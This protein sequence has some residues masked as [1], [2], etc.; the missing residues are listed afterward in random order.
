LN[1]I[2][3]EPSNSH[4]A[5]NNPLTKDNAMTRYTFKNFKEVSR[6]I[7][8]RQYDKIMPYLLDN[9]D[10][11]FNESHSSYYANVRKFQGFLETMVPAYRVFTEGNSKLPFLS[12]SSLPGIHC[13]GAGACLDFCYSFKAWRYAAVFF[14]QCQNQI[15][16]QEN[17]GAIEDAL[18]KQLK[19]KKFSAQDKV[20]IR[21]YVDGDFNSFN[22]LVNWMEC[23]K[24]RTKLKAYGYSKSLHY[25]KRYAAQG[26]DFP[27]NYV[28]NLS[29]GGK[30]TNLYNYMRTLPVTRGEF[31]A[32]DTN[33]ASSA[34]D[35]TKD[36]KKLLYQWAKAQGYK[37]AFVC[38]G[39][40]GDCA[41]T[42]ERKNRHACGD[43]GFF[44]DRPILI[45]VH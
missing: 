10:V 17:F 21:L 45:P 30:Y 4:K 8:F 29:S 34:V 20:D 40:C 6:L 42:R 32:V 38:P 25:F 22:T 31:I 11:S 13:P 14:R 18:D 2:A 44:Q 7:K 41:P 24:N 3:L 1:K 36:E 43:K 19:R 23:L 39:D 27:S 9:T 37:K 16:I 35:R 28:L 12:F 33:A 15:L 5:T 26:L